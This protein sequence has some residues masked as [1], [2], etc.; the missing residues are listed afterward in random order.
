MD[1]FKIVSPA[2]VP[3]QFADVLPNVLFGESP[4][5]TAWIRYHAW[6]FRFHGVVV[7]D[8]RGVVLDSGERQGVARAV[9]FVLTTGDSLA[10]AAAPRPDW[11]RIGTS[12]ASSTASFS[13]VRENR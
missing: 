2:G 3:W 1:S 5:M 8:S 7:R 9:A 10:S 11:D 12:G 4:T 6:F 13:Q